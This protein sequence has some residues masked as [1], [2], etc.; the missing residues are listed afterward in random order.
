[1]KLFILLSIVF[2]FLNSAD[3]S[4]IEQKII[5]NKNI[6]DKTKEEQSKT[7][8]K[9]KILAGE[10]SKEE[11]GF[12]KIQTNL[13]VIS[14]KINANKSQLQQAKT[15]IN[16]LD[17]KSKV[18]E[19]YIS[20]VENNLVRSVT[21][22]Y[23]MSIGKNIINKKS[24]KDIIEQEKLRL[25]LENSR[26]IIAK[27]NEQYVQVT[28]L[29]NANDIQ[30]KTLETVIV[31]GESE[32]KKF[33]DLKK[34]QEVKVLTLRE[35]HKI[36]QN[37]LKAI[38]KQQNDLNRLLGRLNIVKETELEKIKKE[39]LRQQQDN[40]R[41]AK[42]EELRLAQEK[43]ILLKANAN[44][45]QVNAITTAQQ[46]NSKDIKK[47]SQDILENDAD[48]KVRNVGN[49]SSGVK[50]ISSQG[51]RMQAPL[52]SYTVAKKFGDYF[53]PIYK[54]K[55]YNDSV[56]LKSNSKNEK[57]FSALQ[58]QVV[59]AKNDAGSLGNVVIIKHAGD[60]HTIYSRL[61][62]IAPTIVVGKAV[63]QGYVV[64]R[65]QDLLV[66]QATKSNRYLNP[67]ELF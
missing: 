25:I 3:I 5:Y 15:T 26:E 17:Q 46:I 43:K 45:S 31:S 44:G 52:S 66:F 10:L 51:I 11:Q 65:I 23:T 54:I 47:L 21:D 41:K 6:L 19:Q 59:Y 8:T 32:E 29:K 48:M 20:G 36:Y 14:T 40:L 53:D 56:T 50:T 37:E 55:L 1:M 2:S 28:E 16:V 12:E 7:S 62:Q 58:G 67:E 61:S 60:I 22:K 42:A 63:P 34:E 38:V 57:V 4:K 18:I 39:Q 9:I 64:G 33:K 35:K 13:N 49:S 30:K 27:S 24:I